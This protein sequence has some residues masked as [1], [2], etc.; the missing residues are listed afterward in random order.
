MFFGSER[1]GKRERM[2]SRILAPFIIIKEVDPAAR[3]LADA[4]DLLSLQKRDE[5]IAHDLVFLALEMMASMSTGL[6]RRCLT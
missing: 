3:I 6:A 5:F 4:A 2:S 1:H